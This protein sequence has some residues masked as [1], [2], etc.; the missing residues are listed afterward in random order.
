MR[1][2]FLQ[3]LRLDAAGQAHD[4]FLCGVA[5]VVARV[6]GDEEFPVV[7][8]LTLAQPHAPAADDRAGL[9]APAARHTIWIC[10][11]YE[12]EQRLLAIA[13]PEARTWAMPEAAAQ[14][15]QLVA[16]AQHLPRRRAIDRI[17]VPI[18]IE[19]LH[20]HEQ[21]GRTAQ[22]GLGVAAVLVVAEEIL[23]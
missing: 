16:Y 1:E 23:L 4:G 20:P 14:A 21:V 17:V 12:L 11:Q 2:Q 3:P 10:Q 6:G 5:F 7:D 9:T 8:D 18:A 13:R 19:H 22:R 15:D